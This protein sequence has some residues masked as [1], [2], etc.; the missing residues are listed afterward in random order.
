M[1]AMMVIKQTEGEIRPD[2]ARYI[3]KNAIWSLQNDKKYRRKTLIL[4]FNLK[5]SLDLSFRPA[6]S[7]N[8]SLL[9]YMESQY[10]AEVPPPGS[11]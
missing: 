1:N 6:L 8:N 7:L 2:D 9:L 4:T 10:Q 3:F 5:P 11:S